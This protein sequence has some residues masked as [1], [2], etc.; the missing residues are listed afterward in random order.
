MKRSK[1]KLLTLLTVL[2][3]I[4]GCLLMKLLYTTGIDHKG[5]LLQTH[6]AFPGI[7]ILTALVV[8]LLAVSCRKVTPAAGWEAAFP[9]SVIGGLLCIPAAI[10]FAATRIH[11]FFGP[12]GTLDLISAGAGILCCPALLYVGLCRIR[13][14][15][16][17]YLAFCVLCVYFA[18]R[19]V[20]QYRGWSSD[21]QL[22]DYAFYLLSH[23]CLMLSGY[24]L[25]QCSAGGSCRKLPFLALMGSYLGL[26]SLS[27]CPDPLFMGACVLWALGSLPQ[28]EE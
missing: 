28:E 12:V 14:S 19:L 27:V 22:T 23:V 9:R 10:V 7:W 20:S 16:P 13:G 2:A 4:A 3:G 5:L 6:P 8:L 24:Q 17:N 21:P 18:L 15:K 25:A 1:L 11:T 26:I